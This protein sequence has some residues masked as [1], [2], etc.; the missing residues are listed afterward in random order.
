MYD[1]YINEVEKIKN[2]IIEK[3][4][5]NK[6]ILFG[7]V[8]KGL[9]HKSSDI[10]ICIVMDYDSKMDMINKLYMEVDSKLPI[11]F[12]LYK[13]DEWERYKDDTTTFA[14]LIEKNGRVI[15]G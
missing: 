8:A 10:D 12:V 3:F 14:S 9:I 7:F 6:I 5:P 15:Y 1:Y 2:Q 13:I 11:D 4:K